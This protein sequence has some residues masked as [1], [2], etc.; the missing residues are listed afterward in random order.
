MSYDLGQTFF[1]DKAAV[2]NAEKCFITSIDLYFKSKPTVGKAVSGINEPGVSVSLCTVKDDGSPDIARTPIISARREFGDINTSTT[3]TSSTSFVFSK[4]LSVETNKKYGFLI[5]FDGHDTGFELYCNKAGK[6]SLDSTSITQVSSGSVD[7]NAYKITNGYV[8]TPLTDTDLTFKVNVAKFTSLTKTLEIKNRAYE[9]ISA[10]AVTGIFL[11]GEQVY[12][13]TAAV[14]GTVWT[15]GSSNATITGNGT[16]FNALSVGDNIVLKTDPASIVGNIANVRKV[17]SIVNSSVL[18]LDSPP[19]F[20]DIDV[21]L[22]KAAVAKVYDYSFNSD[23]LILTESTSNSS[24]SLKNATPDGGGLFNIIGVDS[25]A[26]ARYSN[27]GILDIRVNNVIPNYSASIPPQTS[28]SLSVIFADTAD[29]VNNARKID[30]KLGKRL[31]ITGYNA[32]IASRTNEVTAA[33]AYKSFNGELTF[34]TTNPYSSPSVSGDDLDVFTERFIINANTTYEPVNK[35]A[36]FARYVGN[37]VTLAQGQV[38]EDM[39]IYIKAFKPANSDI[40]VYVK[41]FNTADS[42]SFDIKNWTE[43]TLNATSIGVTS[44]P[45]NINDF[46]DLGYEV[47]FYSS[48]TQANG[49]F[50]VEATGIVRGSSGTVNSGAQGILPNDLVRVY[51][52]QNTSIYLVDTVVASN[53]SSFTVSR[54]I[55]NTTITDLASGFYVERITDASTAYLDKQKFN[56]LTYFNSAKAKFEGYTSF[57]VKIVLLSNDNTNIPYVDDLQAVAVSA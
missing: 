17:A 39:K 37:Q 49:N 46:K 36:A 41:F 52:P 26:V 23:V 56:V 10:N 33:S 3:G 38:A 40:K 18:I 16:N 1:V 2:Q 25:G 8:L 45:S 42:E 5:R 30:T 43:M 11:G 19:S 22:K 31:A 24:L 57:A 12:V 9:F 14:S 44:N 54:P 50:A 7:G 13:N 32:I 6:L 53:T 21:Q 15:Y 29:T 48:G 28:V 27:S 34:T 47:P 51:H 4:P 20:S 55:T 35:G